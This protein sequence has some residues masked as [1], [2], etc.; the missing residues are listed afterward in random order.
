MIRTTFRILAATAAL[1]TV[2]S[3]AGMARADY[4]CSVSFN[5]SS[6]PWGT[7]GNVTARMYSGPYCTGTEVGN[8]IFCSPGA[9]NSQCPN[10]SSALYERASLVA[11]LEGLRAA[12]QAQQRV[13]VTLVQCIGGA[14]GCA[15]Y[16]TFHGN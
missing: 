8:R 1:W 7:T 2:S 5:P 4:V 12:A 13:T 3:F 9:T 15:G 14:A 6:S 16:L 11:I 10:G